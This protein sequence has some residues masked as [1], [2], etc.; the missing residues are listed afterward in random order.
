MPSV[1]LRNINN[2]ICRDVTLTAQHGELLALMGPTGAGK[3]TLLNV[4]AGLVPYE[5]MVLFDGVPVD[6]LSPRKRRVAYLFQNFCLFPHMNV[7]ENVAFALQVQGLKK[8]DIELRVRELLCLFRIEHLSERYP[9]KGLSGGEK[10]RVALARAVA[11]WPKVLLLDEPF[12]SLDFETAKYLRVELVKLQR[13]L[14]ITTLYVTH[15]QREASEIGDRIA[16]IHQGRLE[17]VG[18]HSQ[19]FFGPKN[20]NVSSLLGS[21]NIFHCKTFFPLTA[22]LAEV[23]LNGFSLV[24][25]YDGLSIEKIAI[26]Q[27]NIYISR[28]KPPGPQ[29]DR[30]RGLI[31]EIAYHSPIVRVSVSCG[32]EQ[33]VLEVQEQLWDETGLHEGDDAFLILPLRWIKVKSCERD[34]HCMRS[35]TGPSTTNH[36]VKI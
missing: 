16:I 2:Y 33:M 14:K 30:L 11:P 18:K 22:S 23:E 32:K 35:I 21:P 36:S 9:N 12:N 25:P 19:V 17:Q 31:L 13:T 1:E 29:I 10:Q 27:W 20:N 34:L 5:G 3:T 4:I 28:E 6:K 8:A 15:N 7:Y 24:V 26:S